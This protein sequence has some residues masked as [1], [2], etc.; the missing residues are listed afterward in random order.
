MMRPMPTHRPSVAP[1]GLLNHTPKDSLASTAVS[2]L[3]EID[4]GAEVAPAG[5]VTVPDAA[6]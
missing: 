4:T 6:V 2:P 1:T 5:M 3:T